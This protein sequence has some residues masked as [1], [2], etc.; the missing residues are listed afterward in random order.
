MFGDDQ[1]RVIAHCW[2][3]SIPIIMK[4]VFGV[5]HRPQLHSWE[6]RSPPLQ[7]SPWSK[8]SLGACRN[9]IC[10][11]VLLFDVWDVCVVVCGVGAGLAESEL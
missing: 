5:G 1:P 8:L 4:P 10:P 11:G 2:T 7:S 9:H 6:G 3:C